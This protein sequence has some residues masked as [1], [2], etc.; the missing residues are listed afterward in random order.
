[1]ILGRFDWL[2]IFEF[3]TL[4]DLAEPVGAV[5]AA[6]MSFGGFDQLEDHGECGV[7]RQAA[8]GLVGPQPNRRECALDRVGAADMLPV[9]GRDVVEGKQGIAI[10][11]ETGAGLSVFRSILGKEAI[12]GLV[13]T[14]SVFSVID[15]MKIALGLFLHRLRQIVQNVG[16]L[17][18]PTSDRKS[19]GKEDAC[20]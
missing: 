12:E 10:L 9:L 5:Q 14:D 16:R 7:A 3:D 18:H 19:S 11:G 13:G 17:V 4:D 1:M 20:S 6:P 2:S 15:L 8:P